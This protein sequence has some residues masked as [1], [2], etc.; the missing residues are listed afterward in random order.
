MVLVRICNM[1]KF[2]KSPVVRYLILSI[3]AVAVGVNVFALNASRLAG[4][5]VPMPF[6]VGASVVLSGSMEPALSVGDLLIVRAQ[7]SYE[8]GDIVIYQSGSMPV[9]HRIVSISDEAVITRGDANNAN[10]E[11]FPITAIRGEVIAVIPLVGYAVWVLKS[12][13][14]VVIMLAAAVLLVEWSVRTGSTEKEAEKEKL[15][16]EIRALMKELEED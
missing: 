14:A 10:D 5:A 7:K 4:N 8:T 2:L 16:E 11:A 6:G 15:K 9:V 3:L 12:P 13:V 1:K